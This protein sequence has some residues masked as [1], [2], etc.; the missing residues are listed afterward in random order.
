ML[1]DNLVIQRIPSHEINTYSYFRN[2]LDTI[3]IY[4]DDLF[5]FL[6]YTAVFLSGVL[7]GIYL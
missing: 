2:D 6:K 3:E 4:V 1:D 7:I 5:T